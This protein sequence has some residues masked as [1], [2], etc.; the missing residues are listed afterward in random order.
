MALPQTIEWRKNALVLLDQ[1]TL[2]EEVRF[3][4]C[5]TAEEVAQAIETMVV[6]G[7]PAI[8]IAA[9]YGLVLEAHKGKEAVQAASERLAR[10]RP[11]AVNLFWALERMKQLSEAT[12]T[13]LLF[14]ALLSEAR[15][16]FE[17]DLTSC[18]AMGAFGASLLP[19]E[20]DV[21][22]HCNAGALATAGHGTALGVIRSAVEEGK[23]IHVYADETR[24][25]LQGARL[26]LWELEEDGI[27]VT[28]MT[29][30]MGAFLMARKTIAAVIVGADRITARGDVANKIGTYAL[31]IAARHHGVPF[32]VAAPR[33]TVDMA[34]QRGED[35]P[36]EERHSE[37]VR[38][39]Q[40]G[41]SCRKTSSVWNPAFDV[42]PPELVTAIIT[43]RGIL[44][45]PYEESL[46]KCMQD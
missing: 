38:S 29:D 11:T 10:T 41:R 45:P 9:A 32:Y 6:R 36:I 15:R 17:E 25:V 21:I 44:R 24:P 2:P 43:E 1:R 30:G 31:A 33:S 7:A 37:E 40:G 35:I 20:G 4:S 18:R 13:S 19:E 34:L 5:H 22:T 8:G 46:Q 14:D 28:L 12:E 23:K 16:I 27:P 3:F 26:T 39:F 42:T